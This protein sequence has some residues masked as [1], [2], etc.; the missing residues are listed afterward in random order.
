LTTPDNGLAAAAVLDI[1]SMVANIPSL[2]LTIPPL[3]ARLLSTI[4]NPKIFDT[5]GWKDPEGGKQESR[6]TIRHLYYNARI[7]IT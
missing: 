2:W 6:E 7:G 1:R 4:D 5:S 3:L